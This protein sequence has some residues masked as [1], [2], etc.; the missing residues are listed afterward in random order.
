MNLNT[1]ARHGVFVL[2]EPKTVGRI[3]ELVGL[4]FTAKGG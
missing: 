2:W 4:L 1:F 3:N